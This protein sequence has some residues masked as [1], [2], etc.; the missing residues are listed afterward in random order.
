MIQ[1]FPSRT[2]ARDRTRARIQYIIIYAQSHIGSEREREEGRQWRTRQSHGRWSMR[3]QGDHLAEVARVTS[4]RK[5]LG[6][7]KWSNPPNSMASCLYVLCS[8]ISPF[9]SLPVVS[10]WI[11][12]FPF[13][14]HCSFVLVIV[15]VCSQVLSICYIFHAHIPWITVRECALWYIKTVLLIVSV[16]LL[17][18]LIIW[19]SDALKIIYFADSS[20]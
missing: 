8:C 1:R 10:L 2:Q 6:L 5:P 12:A 13:T 14:F 17:L 20:W 15:Y 18:S 16:R 4:R 7:G 11:L 3:S 9:W 19:I